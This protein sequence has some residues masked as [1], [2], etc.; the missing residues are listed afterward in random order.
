[1][2]YIRRLL[3]QQRGISLIS[4][5]DLFLQRFMVVLIIMHQILLLCHLLERFCCCFPSSFKV[6]LVNVWQILVNSAAQ[7]RGNV[8]LSE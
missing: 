7:E 3:F 4:E 1:M 2:T 8:S 5:L 6:L